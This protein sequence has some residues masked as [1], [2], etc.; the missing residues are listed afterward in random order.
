MGNSFTVELR[1][2]DSIRPYDRNPRIN[3]KAVEAVAASLK[4]FGFRQP[5]V[6]DAEGVI[7]AGHTRWKAAHQLG[8][9]KVPV[10]VAKDLTPE[11]VRAYRIAD[12][13][14]GE[15]A[16]W[17]LTILPIEIADLQAGGFDLDTIGF[18]EK[19]L[20]KLLSDAAGIKAGLTDPDDVPEPPD[21]AITQRG[22]LWLLGDHRLLCGDSALAT[23]VDRLLD[24]GITAAVAPADSASVHSVHSV[25][26]VHLLIT[27]P[28]TMSASNPAPTTPSPPASARSATLPIITTRRWTRPSTAIASPPTRNSGRRIVPSRTTLSATRI[29]CRCSLH[30][31]AMPRA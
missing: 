25:H 22:D 4:E 15:L 29:F 12:N 26:P 5:I 23:D 28:P 30:G 10:H 3:D 2:I 17:D 7:I 31:S 24:A 11:Q 1:D 9:A 27:D 13:K 8:L 16:E 18:D 21:A 19:E 6:V 20:G 14:T